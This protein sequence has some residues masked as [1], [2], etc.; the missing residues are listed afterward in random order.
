MA[1]APPLRSSF[2]DDARLA[3]EVAELAGEVLLSVR[4]AL[5]D[6][7]PERRG[8]EGDRRAHELIC[9]LLAAARPGDAVLSA[10]GAADRSR[11]DAA[12]VWIVDPLDGTR[13]FGEPGRDDWAVHVA[14]WADGGLAAGAVALPAQG[15]TLTTDPAPVVQ[16]PGPG[17]RPRIVVSRSRP[18][19]FVAPVAEALGAVV[20]PLGSAGAKTMAVVRGQADAYVHAGGQFE[21]DSA[22]PAAVALAAGLHVSRIDGSPTVYN[23]PDPTL[24][25]LLVCRP[26]LAAP[27]LELIGRHTSSIEGRQLE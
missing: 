9:V 24:P 23:R 8:A 12:R 1:G 5:A 18:P 21:C 26:E 25:D 3:A 6:A 10:E 19:A 16:P 2:S 27:L 15:R 17:A 20:V 7:E 11:L 13:E 4:R 22:A 14:L